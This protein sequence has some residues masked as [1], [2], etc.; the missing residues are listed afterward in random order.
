[1]NDHVPRKN[2]E[3]TRSK[4]ASSI[5][6]RNGKEF[7][8]KEKEVDASPKEK[9]QEEPKA[10]DGEASKEE[11]PKGK[12]PPLSDY[13]PVAPF[14]LALNESRKDEEIKEIYET[15]H[16][17]EVNISLL[18][19]IKQ[20]A[21]RSNAYPRGIIEDV[22]VQVNNLAF[23]ADFYVLDMENDYCE[24]AGKYELEV[25]I[26]VPIQRD[27]GIGFS[28]EVKEIEKILNNAPDLPQSGNLAYLSLPISNIRRLPSVLQAPFVELK[29]LPKHLNLEA[30]Q[31]KQLVKVFKEHKTSIGWTITDIK[32]I[33]PSTCI[34][35]ILMEEGVNLSRIVLG[36]VDSSKE[37]EVDKAKIDIIQSLPYPT[38]VREMRS[39]L[40]HAGFYRRYIQDFAKIAAPMCK[41]LRKDVPFEFDEPYKKF[42][43][44]LKDS[45][46]SAPIIQLPNWSNPFEIM[47]DA[48]DFASEKNSEE[49]VGLLIFLAFPI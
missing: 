8:I 24:H 9:L 6:L 39:F 5:T 18:D 19:A 40:G 34:H 4:N 38:S 27:D 20:L 49:G 7:K 17:C 15:F 43:D 48:S 1:M 28:E 10:N 26:T 13:K 11:A 35:R 16:R 41:L 46:T 21:G 36:L 37:I 23:P 12:F 25:D 47:C 32:G 29:M 14:P 33:S 31:E 2:N 30:E 3:E 22:L 42:F 45:L 44:K